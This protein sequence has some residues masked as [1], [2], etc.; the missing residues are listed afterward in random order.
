V[1]CLEV[2]DALD[3]SKRRDLSDT[4]ETAAT[5]EERY[6]SKKTCGIS[7]DCKNLTLSER[8]EQNPM[9][10]CCAYCGLGGIQRYQ[11]DIVTAYATQ[12]VTCVGRS[13]HTACVLPPLPNTTDSCIRSNRSCYIWD[14]C[15]ARCTDLRRGPMVCVSTVMYTICEEVTKELVG[16]REIDIMIF[17]YDPRRI[18]LTSRVT[19]IYR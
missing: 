2:A 10:C 3:P 14:W 5:V 1:H 12:S 6:A 9:S 7:S 15:S 17:G 16:C 4:M 8:G 13:P 19:L 11:H 18:S